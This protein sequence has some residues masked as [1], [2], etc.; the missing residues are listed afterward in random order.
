[1]NR[2]AAVVIL[3]GGASSRMQKDKAMLPIEGVPLILRLIRQLEPYFHSISISTSSPGKFAFTG[4]PIIADE[5]PGTSPLHAI[6]T[7][8]KQ[9]EYQRNLFIA[10]DIPEIHP[11]FLFRMLTMASEAEIVVP[12]YRD[13]KLE[14][15]FAIYSRAVIPRIAHQIESIQWKI[16]HLFPLCQTL[17]IP[18]DDEPW[19][20]NLNTRDDYL[21]Y[22]RKKGISQHLHHEWK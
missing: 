20:Q 13:G 6:F 8:L 11:P 4:R 19:F 15:L 21:K 2:E 7:C 10:C 1:M 3:A 22:L 14:P 12:R 18:M 9:S 17:Y 5:F 16:A